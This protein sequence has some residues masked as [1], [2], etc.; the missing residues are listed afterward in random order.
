MS[1][2]RPW[3]PSRVAQFNAALPKDFKVLCRLSE[4][5][6]VNVGDLSPATWYHFRL[7][8]THQTGE[9]VSEVTSVAT[10]CDVP[11]TPSQIKG[12]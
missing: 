10:K 6:V 5:K 1:E 3:K 11:D 7:R 4:A 8:A 9:V 2:G 12:C